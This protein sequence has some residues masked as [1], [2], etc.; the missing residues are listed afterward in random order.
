LSNRVEGLEVKKH[1]REKKIIDVVLLRE[2]SGMTAVQSHIVGCDACREKYERYS[3]LLDSSDNSSLAPSP[4]VEARI[5]QSFRRE[6]SALPPRKGILWKPVLAMAVLLIIAGVIFLFQRD[7]VQPVSITVNDFNGRVYVDKQKVERRLEIELAEIRTEMHSQVTLSYPDT[8][9]I[10]LLDNTALMV[11]EGYFSKKRDLYRFSFDLGRGMVYAVFPHDHPRIEYSF[12]TPQ[13]RIY[14]IGTEFLLRTSERES[15]LIMIDGE[16][17]IQCHSGRIAKAQSGKRYRITESIEESDIEYNEL[18]VL[19]VRNSTHKNIRYKD[20]ISADTVSE[21]RYHE[22]KGMPVTLK[23]DETNESPGEK[24][25]SERRKQT[26][27]R[28]IRRDIKQHQRT[29]RSMR[30][31]ARSSQREVRKERQGVKRGKR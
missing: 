4:S 10:T 31:D 1:P 23:K 18:R 14:S 15:V 30:R 9:D 21:K 22:K 26:E 12:N 13:A 6:M 17:Q 20:D 19:G 11:T 16:L 25:S 3:A 28:E 29:L 5:A 7:S 27:L 8:F 2:E 24:Y